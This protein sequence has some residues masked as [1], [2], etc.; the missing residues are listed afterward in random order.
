MSVAPRLRLNRQAETKETRRRQRGRGGE[1][2][3]GRRQQRGD[4]GRDARERF[5]RRQLPTGLVAPLA[6]PGQLR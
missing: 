2:L 3:R 1:G 6:A 4:G 5:L